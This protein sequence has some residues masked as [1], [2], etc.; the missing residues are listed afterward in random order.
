MLKGKLKFII[1]IGAIAFAVAYLVY[2]GVRE[3]MV[4]YLTVEELHARVPDVYGERVRVSGNVIPGTIKHGADG[5]LEFSI[6]DGGGAVNVNYNGIVP[7]VFKDDVE[8]VVEGVY[9]ESGVFQADILLAK[10]PTKYESTDVLYNDQGAPQ[11]T[12][13]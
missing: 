7:D 12:S 6:T 1:A 3:T 8:A 2:G 11:G 13:Y 10:C 9:S 4:Y 5:A